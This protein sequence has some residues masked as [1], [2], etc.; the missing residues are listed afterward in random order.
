VTTPTRPTPT[1]AGGRYLG[2]VTIDLGADRV[3]DSDGA[4]VTPVSLGRAYPSGL[5]VTQDGFPSA[6][7][8]NRDEPSN[9]KFTPWERFAAAFRPRLA[10]GD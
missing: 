6:V 5:L 7:D 8:P 2:S 4:D 9:F 10:V 3:Q 1:A